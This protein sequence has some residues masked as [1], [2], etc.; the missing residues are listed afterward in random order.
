[1]TKAD[2]WLTG[3][4]VRDWLRQGTKE[5]FRVMDVLHLDYDG[6]GYTVVYIGQNSNCTL[7]MGAI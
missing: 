5:H 2:Q 4:G 7:K 6:G 1:M 3:V